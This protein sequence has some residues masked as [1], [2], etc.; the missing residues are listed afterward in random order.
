MVNTELIF[1]FT[2]QSR[3]KDAKWPS[4]SFHVE[5][6]QFQLTKRISRAELKQPKDFL[7]VE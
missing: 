1:Y 2:Y 7:K 5:H 4:K 3:E 6:L